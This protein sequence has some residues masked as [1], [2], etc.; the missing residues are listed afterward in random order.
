MAEH[1]CCIAKRHKVPIHSFRFEIT[2]SALSYE[3][4]LRQNMDMLIA[5]G[6]VLSL[7]DFGTGYS[8]LMRVLKF[9]FE[10]VKFDM[11]FVRAYFDQTNKLLPAIISG[12]SL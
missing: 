2:E 10:D 5:Q 6:A 4:R 8:N 1:L 3:Q 12:T 11:S 7:D 9:P